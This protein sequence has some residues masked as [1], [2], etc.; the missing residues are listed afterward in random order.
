M[1]NGGQM[2]TADYLIFIAP[3]VV[4]VLAVF[5]M[6]Y[7]AA[8]SQARARLANDGLYQALAEKAVAVQTDNQAALAAIRAD[9]ARFG[10]S[11]ATVEKVLQQ[12]E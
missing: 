4:T 3:L 8:M 9:L 1:G 10:A 11:L 7:F 6:K 12:V 2:G 5:G